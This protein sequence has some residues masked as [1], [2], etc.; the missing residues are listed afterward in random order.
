MWII[1]ELHPIYLKAFFVKAIPMLTDYIKFN[2]LIYVRV[3]SYSIYLE[4]FNL[5]TCM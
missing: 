1:L 5:Y 3:F 4:E 2:L